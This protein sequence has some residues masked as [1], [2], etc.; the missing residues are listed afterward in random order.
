MC[1]TEEEDL[2][3][4]LDMFGNKLDILNKEVKEALDDINKTSVYTVCHTEHL[5]TLFQCEIAIAEVRS[6]RM[7]G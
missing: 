5:V 7:Q 4:S 6:G 3:N 2:K 1:T